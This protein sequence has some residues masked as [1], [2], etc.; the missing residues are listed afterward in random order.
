MK[1]VGKV[2]LPNQMYTKQVD[3]NTSHQFAAPKF[4]KPALS[5]EPLDWSNFFDRKERINGVVPLYIA[6]D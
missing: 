6:G 2:P 1:E 5:Y 3:V 4:N